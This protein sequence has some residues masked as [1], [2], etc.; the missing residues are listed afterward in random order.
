MR[1][2][3]G[4]LASLLFATA[5]VAQQPV[6]IKEWPVPWTDTRPRDPA[7]DK[8]GK[9][10]F[11]GQTGNYLARFD[12]VTAKF[13]RYDLEKGSGPHNC[14]VG[15]DGAIWFAGN[16]AA[17]I[18][19]FD[20]ATA[21]ITR[22]A[23]PDG[24]ASDPHTLVTAP[25]GEIWFTAQTSGYVG[26]LNPKSGAVKVV[27]VEAR[28]A[29]PY[30]IVVDPSGKAWFNEFGRNAIGSVGPNSMTIA[31]HMLPEGARDRRLALAGDGAV[32]YVDYAR[33]FLARLDPKSGAAKEWQTPGGKGSLPYA[34]AA[35]DRGRFWFVESGPQ[36]NRLVGFDPKSAAFFSVTP[37]PSGGGTV[38][39]MVFDP[40][41]REIWFGTDAGTIGRARVP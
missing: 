1:K 39:H 32:W 6:E 20:P 4:I 16:T 22:I 25:N 9:V 28:G 23:M 12:P 11:V 30:G 3:R 14:I 5:A 33:G 35:D 26:R 21:K 13:D 19:R 34:M 10:W 24:M 38:R 7:V 15:P 29:R 17:Y 37:I 27:K 41:K 8:Q 31:E 36:P 2:V 40:A 18:G